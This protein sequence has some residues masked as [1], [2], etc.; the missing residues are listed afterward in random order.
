M[1]G[2]HYTR[3]NTHPYDTGDIEFIE[4]VWPWAQGTYTSTHTHIG[5]AVRD[6][7][8]TR[9]GQPV[10]VIARAIPARGQNT[11]DGTIIM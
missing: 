2:K 6:G 4:P 7:P 3:G 5:E 1:C 8:Y 10:R 9:I 11:W